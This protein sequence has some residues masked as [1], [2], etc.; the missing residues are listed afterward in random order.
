M[1]DATI[2][3]ANTLIWDPLLIYLLLGAGAYFTIRTRFIQFRLFGHFWS[4][5][6]HSREGAG[7]GISG[8]QAFCIGLAS[9]VGTGNIAGVAIALTLGGRARSSGC[10]WSPLSAWRPPSS[11]PR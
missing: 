3:W 1:L 10:G 7:Q 9:R 6:S 2:Q 8:F 4:A 11:R 5:L